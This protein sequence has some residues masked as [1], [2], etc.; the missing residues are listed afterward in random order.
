MSNNFTE[1]KRK[2]EE[3]RIFYKREEIKFNRLSY[4]LS[5]EIFDD[6]IIKKKKKRKQEIIFPHL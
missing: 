2:K 3:K 5:R 1:L 4:I 6:F